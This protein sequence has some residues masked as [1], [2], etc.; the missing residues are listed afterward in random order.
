MAAKVRTGVGSVALR[1]LGKGRGVH[2]MVVRHAPGKDETQS[3]Q[4]TSMVSAI[5]GSPLCSKQCG[6]MGRP[7]APPPG[8]RGGASRTPGAVP[9]AWRRRTPR[10]GAHVRKAQEGRGP[11]GALGTFRPSQP[12]R[13]EPAARGAGSRGAGSPR[14]G[15]RTARW[16][17]SSCAGCRKTGSC[18]PAAAACSAAEEGDG[19]ENYLNPS[20]LG[21]K[22]ELD[23]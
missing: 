11:R 18:G 8:H 12:E 19:C 16:P 1:C 14:V 6:C 22:T 23:G 3:E 7:Q 15:A 17:R 21:I 13:Q 4:R 10:D 2:A 5:S 20:G 9:H